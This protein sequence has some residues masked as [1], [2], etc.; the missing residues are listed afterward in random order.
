MCCQKVGQGVG[1]GDYEHDFI[2]HEHD[3]NKFSYN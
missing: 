1:R 2:C 3:K